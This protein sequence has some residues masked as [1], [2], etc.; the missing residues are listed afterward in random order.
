VTKFLADENFD[1]GLVRGLLQAAPQVD[2]VRVQDVGL[3]GAADPDILAWAAAEQR[4]TL[5][6]D[7]ATMTAHAIER[8]EQGEP[9][10]GLIEVTERLPARAVIDDL[11]LIADASFPGEWEGRILYV[12]LR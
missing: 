4:V 3:A 12:P 11:L 2:L 7:V 6:H 8:I 9:M 5:T 10:P 1:N